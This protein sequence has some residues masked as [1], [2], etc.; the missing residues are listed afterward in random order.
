M[1]KNITEK[2]EEYLTEAKQYSLGEIEEETF[3]VF[4]IVIKGVLDNILMTDI[5]PEEKNLI[6]KNQEKLVDSVVN[7]IEDIYSSNSKI[8]KAFNSDRG[9]EEADKWITH[10]FLGSIADIINK[11]LAM[12][13]KKQL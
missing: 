4:G 6:G 12:K 3:L 13:I 1:T 10:W 8:R 2:I 11:E 7:K 5:T 9:N